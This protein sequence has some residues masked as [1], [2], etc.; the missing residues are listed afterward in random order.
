[1]LFLRRALL[2]DDWMRRYNFGL[3]VIQPSLELN[4]LG[5]DGPRREL[6]ARGMNGS[7]YPGVLGVVVAE[8]AFS[9]QGVTLSKQAAACAHGKLQSE[10]R[11]QVAAALPA[12]APHTSSHFRQKQHHALAAALQRKHGCDCKRRLVRR[13]QHR[14]GKVLMQRWDLKQKGGVHVWGGAALILV[15]VVGDGQRA[16]EDLGNLVAA[17]NGIGRRVLHRGVDDLRV[18][19]DANVLLLMKRRRL[20]PSPGRS[21]CSSRLAACRCKRELQ[22]RVSDARDVRAANH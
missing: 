6:V 17:V 7:L 20:P 11:Q 12:H 9:K 5:V 10:A 15:V 22:Q 8:H 19:L 3:P 13:L 2:A 14:G 16:E 4:Q 21:G 18:P 1:M